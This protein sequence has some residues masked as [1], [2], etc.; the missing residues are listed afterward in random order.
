MDKLFSKKAREFIR[1]VK[2]AFL[3]GMQ[4]STGG[5][6]SL[7]INENL[8][9]TK[10]SGVSLI[11]CKQNNLIVVNTKGQLIK[12][13]K[14]PTKEIKFHLGI[15]DVRKDINA[16]VHYHSPWTTAFCTQSIPI[17][18]ITLHAKRILNKI[19]IIPE[20]K[21]GSLKLAKLVTKEF[22][23]PQIWAITLTKHGLIA[24][25]PTLNFAENIAELIEETAKTALL[26]FLLKKF[27]YSKLYDLE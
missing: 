25:G 13:N 6:I 7:K 18:L 27:E 12:G 20:A 24:A 23:N 2:K 22:V 26:S 10:P 3:L 9:L 15:Y 14:K 1:I 5:N 21:E 11:D 17:P 4:T 19:P 16:I 8:I